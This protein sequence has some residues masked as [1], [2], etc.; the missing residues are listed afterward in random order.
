MQYT[1]EVIEK[2]KKV[3][4]TNA[5]SFPKA[6]EGFWFEGIYIINIFLD[7]TGKKQLSFEESC[8]YYGHE[9]IHKFMD[10]VVSA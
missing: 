1:D 5:L 9:N 7:K 2:A 3:G 6:K 8:K 4:A 10:A